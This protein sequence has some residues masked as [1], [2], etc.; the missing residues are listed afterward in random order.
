MAGL[1]RTGRHAGRRC[2]RAVRAEDQRAQL[3]ADY[4]TNHDGKLDADEQMALRD[5]L[6]ARVRG[7]YFK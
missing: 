3:E 1:W 5:Y 6:R 2:R 7:E 4:D